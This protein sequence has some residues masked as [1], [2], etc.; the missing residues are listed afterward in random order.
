LRYFAYIKPLLARRFF[1]DAESAFGGSRSQFRRLGPARSEIKRANKAK[2][3]RPGEGTKFKTSCSTA[4]NT[5]EKKALLGSWGRPIE[6]D[7]AHQSP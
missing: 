2:E 6:T 5:G 7:G 4:P 1:S 3:G